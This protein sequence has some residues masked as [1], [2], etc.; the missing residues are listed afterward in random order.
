MT[1]YMRDCAC[2]WLCTQVFTWE[3]SAGCLHSTRAAL[4]FF[5]PLQRLLPPR[6]STTSLCVVEDKWIWI[7]HSPCLMS[8]MVTACD[9][10]WRSLVLL[11]TSPGVCRRSVLQKEQCRRGSSAAN[12]GWRL[13]FW[14]FAERV[15]Y[16]ARLY[17]LPLGPY[18]SISPLLIFNTDFMPASCKF[19]PVTSKYY[20]LVF[21]TKIY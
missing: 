1:L 6:A 4:F 12:S 17:C 15:D 10:S 21:S 18:F 19:Q 5:F 14:W 16:R 7:I 13:A 20:S 3:R 11:S 8:H 2:T 9:W